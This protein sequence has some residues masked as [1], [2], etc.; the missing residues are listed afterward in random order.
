MF[1]LKKIHYHGKDY[2]GV[3]EDGF[4]ADGQS[5]AGIPIAVIKDAVTQEQWLVVREQRDKLLSSCDWTQVADSP[6]TQERKQ[7]WNLYRQ[8][9]R[10]LPEK[11]ES[12]ENVVWPLAPN[13]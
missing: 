11:F 4:F 6:L 10:D 1:V 8:A 7:E 13:A 5:M 12:P 3:R 2:Y 9:L